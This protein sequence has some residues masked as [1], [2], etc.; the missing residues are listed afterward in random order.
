MSRSKEEWIQRTG[1]FRIGESSEQFAQR[2][3]EIQ[4]LEERIKCGKGTVA[5]VNRIARL[6]GSDEEE[7]N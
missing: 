3:S 2:T 1:G 6:K 4:R 7:P 5:D